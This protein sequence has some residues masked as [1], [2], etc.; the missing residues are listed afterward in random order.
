MKNNRLKEL[1]KQAFD[2]DVSGLPDNIDVGEVVVNLIAG[3]PTLAKLVP[4]TGIK[5]G[6]TEQLN[7]LDTDV[8]WSNGQCVTTET[9]DN[10]VITDRNLTTAQITDRELLCLDQVSAK[11]PMYMAAG[12]DNQDL[13]FAGL[14]TNYKIQTK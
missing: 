7:I 6:S 1:E 14:W 10:T 13:D 12:A 4:Q 5:A 3:A 11:L 9:G 2:I 8:T